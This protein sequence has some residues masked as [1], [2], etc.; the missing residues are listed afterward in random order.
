MDNIFIERLWW[1]VKYHYLYLHAFDSGSKLREGLMGWFKYYN[2]QRPHQGLDDMTPDEGLLRRLF[3]SRGCVMMLC[4]SG[5]SIKAILCSRVCG[6][7][8]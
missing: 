2:S 5:L 7:C 8:Q 4:F 3:G 6:A 1:T